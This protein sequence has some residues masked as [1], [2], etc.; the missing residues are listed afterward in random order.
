[1]PRGL[2]Q[3]DRNR[4]EV[5]AVA[6]RRVNSPAGQHAPTMTERAAARRLAAAAAAR[7]LS[8][9]PKHAEPEPDM[10]ASR[11]PAS[12]AMAPSTSAIWG[13]IEMA[14]FSRSLRSDASQASRASRL[15]A[16][17]EGEGA[18]AYCWPGARPSAL[19]TGPV[20]SARPGWTIRM[21][22]FGRTRGAESRSPNAAHNA[23]P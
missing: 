11:H 7:A 22:S 16:S 4:F 8:N 13:T 18:F 9:R 12:P 19:K 23:R 15:A 5:R 1:M 14:A 20:G 21:P 2:I 17:P 6:C 10:R 3:S